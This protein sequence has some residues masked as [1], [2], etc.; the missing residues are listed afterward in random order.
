MKLSFEKDNTKDV[1]NSIKD[2]LEGRKLNDMVSFRLDGDDLILTISK[3]GTSTVNFKYS[4]NSNG[5]TW[6]VVKEK[7]AFSHKAFKGEVMEKLIK[8]VEQ[9]GGSAE[10]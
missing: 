8:V 7:I 6:D 2:V 5:F 1:L 3:L 10:K 9:V 4:K